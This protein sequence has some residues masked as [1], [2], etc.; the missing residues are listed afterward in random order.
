MNRY[1]CPGAMDKV[2]FIPNSAKKE[3]ILCPAC[4]AEM[5]MID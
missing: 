2:W 1:I 4:G 5:E 3:D